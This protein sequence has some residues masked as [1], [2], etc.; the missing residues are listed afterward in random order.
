MAKAAS[1]LSKFP[2]HAHKVVFYCI[3]AQIFSELPF[4]SEADSF[5]LKLRVRL[6]RLDSVPNLVILGPGPVVIITAVSKP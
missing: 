6:H 1:T 2:P 4:V 3:Y 5:T